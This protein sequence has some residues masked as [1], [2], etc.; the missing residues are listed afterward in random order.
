MTDFPD[1]EL[2]LDNIYLIYVSKDTKFA[3][4]IKKVYGEHFSFIDYQ[5]SPSGRTILRNYN[6]WNKR[7]KHVLLIVSN[8][9]KDMSV[10]LEAE[11]QILLGYKQKR[12]DNYVYAIRFEE[13]LEEE[14]VN[15]AGGFG[16][17][18][19]IPL[20]RDEE[21]TKIRDDL[22]QHYYRE[23][24]KAPQYRQTNTIVSGSPTGTTQS[25]QPPRTSRL[26]VSLDSPVEHIMTK[27]PVVFSEDD[28]I[29]DVVA[30]WRLRGFR[31]FP[32]TDKENHL[33]G[34]V[35]L[36][37]I[38]RQESVEENVWD[39]LKLGGGLKYPIQKRIGD[40]MIPHLV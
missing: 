26:N 27:N 21:P 19:Y 34:I 32:I 1:S 6:D 18:Q 14:P 16:T 12:K 36:R 2:N 13:T 30:Y 24:K 35:T 29:S 38:I 9:W 22:L 40:F 7:A 10:Y 11:L 37:D 33:I 20:S 4:W 39:Y 23:F 25:L 5:F 15:M 28:D 8:H 31:H 17:I 3:N